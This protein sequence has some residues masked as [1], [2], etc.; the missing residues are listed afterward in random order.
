MLLLAD[1]AAMGASHLIM[2]HRDE[3]FFLLLDTQ[4]QKLWMYR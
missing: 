1:L 2:Y 4:E 3:V